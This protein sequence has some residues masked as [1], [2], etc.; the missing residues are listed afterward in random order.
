MQGKAGLFMNRQIP[1]TVEFAGLKVTQTGVRTAKKC[2]RSIDN[3]PAPTNI[4]EVRSIFGMIN[5]VNYE[6]A[7][8]CTMDPLRHLMKP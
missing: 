6:F 3:F 5:L 4:S 1:D 7:M 2:L 8:N